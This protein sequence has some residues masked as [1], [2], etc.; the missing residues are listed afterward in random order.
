MG[1]KHI[2]TAILSI[3][4][5]LSL[6]ACG[7]QSTDSTT[8]NKK[9]YAYVPE[10][11]TLEE[12]DEYTY[13]GNLNLKGNSL[14]Y[15]QYKYDEATETSTET[16]CEYSLEDG[17]IKQ[18]PLPL[19]ENRSL[20]GY[21]T[22]ADGN[23]Y[24]V[25]SDY[26][27]GQ[28]SEEGYTIPDIYLQ[29]YDTQGTLVFE[30][31]ITKVITRVGADTYIQDILVD[32]QGKIYICAESAVLLF[33]NEGQDEGLIEMSNGWIN[34]IGLDKDGKVYICYYDDTSSTGGMALSELDYAGQKIGKTYRNVPNMSS[35][36]FSV[37]VEK[38]LLINDGTRVYEY[39]MASETYEEIF[40]WLEC[41]ID[42][43][44]VEYVG[45]TE[46]GTILA[47]IRD[48]DTNITE[49]AKLHK[50]D[51]SEVVQKEEIVIGTLYDSQELQAAAVAFNK[52]NDKYH[53]TIKTYI[54]NNNWTET[55]YQDALTNLN[56]EITSG[57]NCP[58]ILDLSQLNEQQLAAK[59]VLEDLTPYLEK[60]TTFSKEDFVDNLLEGFTYDGVLVAIPSTF[61]LNTVVGKSSEVG[62]EMGWSLEEMMTFAKE[63]EGAQL[64]DAVDQNT[65]MQYCMIYNQDTFVD[66]TKG[67][68]HF[69]SDEF[70][71]LLEFVAMF[72][73]E[74]DWSTYEGG[75]KVEE[76][77]AGE[78]LLE[79]AYIYDFQEIQMYPAMYGEPVTFIGFP[80]TD[81]SVGCMMDAGTRYG[82]T[83]KSE[84]KDGAWA[85]IES[86]LGYS[87]NSNYSWGFSTLKDRLQ[88]QIE[89]ITKVEY[90]LDENGEQ[91]L[92]ENGEPIVISGTSSIGWE[93]WEYTYHTPTQEEVNQVKEL[94]AV[95]KP[96]SNAGN[97]EILTIISEEAAAYFK[98]Q[99]TIDEVVGIIQSRVQIYISE[100]S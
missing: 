80:T 15:S 73:Q 65:M 34:S 42:G 22:D 74:I 60:S 44:H 48:W 57:A 86:Y 61:S 38:D 41:D 13:F 7:K 12:G 81:G 62:E 45:A 2:I 83:A 26:S 72:P 75:A 84:N 98:G 56:N 100:N 33:N 19:A 32:E 6:V 47:V 53:V 88:K 91:M 24:A 16:I 37:G 29:K 92:D 31:D 39:E 63:H 55:S 18:I 79:S 51:A 10:Y 25:L 30:K 97:D 90:M 64:F 46:D 93:D 82:I 11:I 71:T 68:C 67:E 35:S 40:S 3:T 95:A 94:I 36:N 4:M 89:E 66:W 49:I 87:E 5:M 50:T 28:V 76:K 59:G 77:Q 9:D 99:K 21:A 85:F 43:S 78:I 96:V 8:D 69:D 17:S 27:V 54:D 52:A 23:I 70:R 20:S 1:K 58:D 14:Y